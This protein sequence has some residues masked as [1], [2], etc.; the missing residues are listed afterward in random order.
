M[1]TY[2]ALRPEGRPMF[3]PADNQTEAEELVR[4][5]VAEGVLKS[6]T[7]P[8]EMLDQGQKRTSEEHWG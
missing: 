8:F 5:L 4:Q 7:R 3:F 1:Q 6:Y 2:C